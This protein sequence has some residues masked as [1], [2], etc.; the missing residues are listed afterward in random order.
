[1]TFRNL[2]KIVLK[3]SW[4]EQKNIILHVKIS[5]F[6]YEVWGDKVDKQVRLQIKKFILFKLKQIK[7]LPKYKISDWDDS[8]YTNYG[9]VFNQPIILN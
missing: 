2:F 4:Q 5:A 6:M 3:K 8:E 7:P 1:M 9:L